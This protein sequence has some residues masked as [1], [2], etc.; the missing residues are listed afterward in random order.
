[1]KKTKQ[2]PHTTKNKDRIWTGVIPGRKLN[3]PNM[4]N[5]KKL[6]KNSRQG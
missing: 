3:F 4:C 1:M 2:K 5:M 6:L